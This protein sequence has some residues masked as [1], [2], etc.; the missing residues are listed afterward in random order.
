M[1]RS[2]IAVENTNF[3]EDN[4]RIAPGDFFFFH[5]SAILG[6]N[7]SCPPMPLH[8]RAYAKINLGLLVVR[9]REDGYHDIET[10]FHRIDL[11][12]RLTF[13]PD[14]R[15]V[16]QADRTEV[17]ED[18]RNLCYRAALLLRE[19]LGVRH[20]ARIT[21]EKHIPVGAGLGGGS[22]DAASTLL[23]LTELWGAEVNEADL[24][25]VALHLGSDVPYFLRSG[26]AQAVGRG[27][28]LEYFPLELPYT[29]LVVNPGI[30]ISTSWAYGRITPGIRRPAISL[31]LALQQGVEAPERLTGFLRNDFE[32]VVFREHPAVGK[33]KQEILAGGAA[34][35][36]MSGSGSTVYGLFR[37]DR[38]AAV[39]GELFSHRGFAVS[40]TAPLFTA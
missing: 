33:L 4:Q 22:S 31:K 23:A 38:D 26:T 8:A 5:L 6:A 19:R 27:E 16:I 1:A 32:D 35:A 17:P 2:V 11:F 12:D 34:F 10:I 29:I 9:R 36:S 25:S 30:H 40:L 28:I 39:L 13:E 24:A 3:E 15:I 18:E 14:E 37:N 20:G 7:V 21:I